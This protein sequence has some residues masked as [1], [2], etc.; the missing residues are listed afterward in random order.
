MMILKKFIHLLTRKTIKLLTVPRKNGYWDL[1]VYDLLNNNEIRI[2]D[3]PEYEGNPTWSPDGLF[4]AFDSYKNGNLDIFIKS[5]EAI[6]L[7]PIQLTNSLEADFSPA[8]SPSGR[9]IAFVSTRSGED[10]I[11]IALLDNVENRFTNVS[12]SPSKSDQHPAWSNDGNYL[13]W[14]S[15]ANGYPILQKYDLSSRDNEFTPIL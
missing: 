15:D 7:A 8:W 4:I 2:T 9:E 10:E 5:L 1:Y 14:S 11:W 3:T 13:I 12:K 6:D